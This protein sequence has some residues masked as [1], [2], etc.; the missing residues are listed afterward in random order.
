MVTDTSCNSTPAFKSAPARARRAFSM[1]EL[2]VALT[3][4]VTLLTS[5]LVAL[6][7]M[8]K[9]YTV[10]S[11]SASTHVIARTVM[12]RVLAMV[13]TGQD[14]GP[15]PADPTDPA[16]NPRNYDR[17]EFISRGQRNVGYYE[18]T[19]IEVRAADTRTLMGEQVQ[20]RG[21]R[22]L[23]MTIT[24]INNGATVSTNSFPLLDGV[25]A[26]TF[27]LDY[28]PGPRLVRATVDMTISPTGNQVQRDVG[29]G[30]FSSSNGTAANSAITSD[31]TSQT[32]RLVASTSPRGE[33]E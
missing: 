7:S 2:L 33:V 4:S 29:T 27:N 13:R 9:R 12:H 10:I 5:A 8:F 21:P 23:W 17:I 16:Q 28:E 15:Y 6:D 11:D 25:I 20:L 30:T 31:A 18:V 19:T 3:I 1:I 32:I 24:G 22:V 26:C 14:F